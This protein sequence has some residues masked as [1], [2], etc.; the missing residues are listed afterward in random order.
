MADLIKA[1]K[2]RA[3]GLSNETPF[4]LSSF[5]HTASLLGLP[6]P[7][8]TQN[9]YSL[10]ERNDF[11]TGM[12]EVC[13]PHNANIGLLAYSPLAAGAL[14]GKYINMRDVDARARMKHFVGFMHRYINPLAREAVEHYKGAADTLGL[15]LAQVAL[16]FVYSRPFVTSTILGAT[17]ASQLEDDILALNIPVTDEAFR[18][19][20]GVYRRYVDP[21]KGVFE[22]LD[23]NV[24]YVDASKLPWGSK[25]ED[26]DPE[27]DALINQ[28]AQKF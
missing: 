20:N 3:Y 24:E 13:S 17:S 12:Q 2:I 7:V 5:Y 9:A 1:G 28:R 14:T 21:T 10:L 16:A 27:M 18:L 23:P 26:V 25:D 22:V 4:G 19:L 15:P 8:V 6:R 11:E